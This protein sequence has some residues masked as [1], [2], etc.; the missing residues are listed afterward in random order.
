MPFIIPRVRDL[1]GLPHEG[2]GDCVTLIK[3]LAPGLKGLPTTCWQAG[4]RVL[5]VKNVVPGTAIATFIDGKYPRKFTGN[6]AA[7]F[8]G[9]SGDEIWVIEQFKNNSKAGTIDFRLIHRPQR[10]RNGTF[11]RQ[12]PSNNP[13]MYYVIELARSCRK[14]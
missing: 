2:E 7:F 3:N 10:L 13:Q 6:H 9:Y 14:K 1:I 12:T 4:T 8:W 11:A 5:D